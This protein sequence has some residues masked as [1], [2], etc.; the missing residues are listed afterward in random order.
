MMICGHQM[1]FCLHGTEGMGR[2]AMK[3]EMQGTEDEVVSQEEERQQRALCG[4]CLSFR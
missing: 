4:L 3:Q 1:D 2:P